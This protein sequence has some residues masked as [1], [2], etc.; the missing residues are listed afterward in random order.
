MT[1]PTTSMGGRTLCQQLLVVVTVA[2]VAAG[3]PFWGVG[4]GDEQGLAIAKR[5]DFLGLSI[6]DAAPSS[7]CCRGVRHA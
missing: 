3:F 2:P 6:S 4:G 7:N 5:H 1:E